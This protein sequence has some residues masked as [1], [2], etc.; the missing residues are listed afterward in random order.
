MSALILPRRSF[1]AGLGSLLAAPAVIKAESLMRVG[2]IDHILYPMRGLVTYSIGTDS[3]I[4]RVDRANFPLNMR[5]RGPI[6]QY[7]TEQQIIKL[8][9]K[10]QLNSILPTELMQQKYIF[11][12]FSSVEWLEKGLL[13]KTT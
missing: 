3:L 11:K 12:P 4:V 6:E 9:T 2:N 10:E 7:L 1:L 13:F 5:P 8:F